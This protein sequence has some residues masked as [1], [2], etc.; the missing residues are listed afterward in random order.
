MMRTLVRKIEETLK[1]S[2]NILKNK[3]VQKEFSVPKA[4]GDDFLR[5]NDLAFVHL[6]PQAP[7]S[8]TFRA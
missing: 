7:V 6:D 3:Y 4:K 5:T 2:H 8:K 1:R